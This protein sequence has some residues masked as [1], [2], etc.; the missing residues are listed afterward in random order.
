[1][2]ISVIILTQNRAG[3]LDACLRSLAAQAR[4]ADEVVVESVQALLAA[5]SRPLLLEVHP[6][7]DALEERKTT[8][9]DT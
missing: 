7:F 9:V 8:E 5:P 6:K 1:M 2:R 4:P 3:M